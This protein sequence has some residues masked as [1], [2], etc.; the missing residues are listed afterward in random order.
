VSTSIQEALRRLA[1]AVEEME[2]RSADAAAL[3]EHL[4]NAVALLRWCE[5]AGGSGA[6]HSTVISALEAYE[7]WK[8]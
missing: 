3:I 1:E 2:V 5:L 4:H 6:D 7:A 8:K